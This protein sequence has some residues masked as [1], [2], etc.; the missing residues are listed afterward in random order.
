MSPLNWTLGRALPKYGHWHNGHSGPMA[1]PPICVMIRSY[2]VYSFAG[3]QTVCLSMDIITASYCQQP[4]TFHNVE[5]I[6]SKMCVRKLTY[7]SRFSTL[8]GERDLFSLSVCIV[9]PML[10]LVQDWYSTSLC[11]IPCNTSH[12]CGLPVWRARLV[13][14]WLFSSHVIFPCGA[15]DLSD[16]EI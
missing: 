6:D 5:V 13:D 15:P 3:L 8:S 12:A 2:I 9:T 7:F 11:F 10:W 14:I 1:M 4:N 16:S